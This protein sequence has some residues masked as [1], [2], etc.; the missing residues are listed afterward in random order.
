MY[1]TIAIDKDNFTS[2]RKKIMAKCINI[3]CKEMYQIFPHLDPKLSS[4][5]LQE[6][7][8]PNCKINNLFKLIFI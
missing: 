6:I 4:Q 3:K 7:K 8:C 5:S 1:Q 2:P